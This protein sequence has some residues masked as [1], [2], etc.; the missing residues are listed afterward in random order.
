MR[1]Q[2]R[3]GGLL[4]AASL[5]LFGCGLLS[6]GPRSPGTFSY[7]GAMSGARENQ[8]ATLLHDGRVLVAG[9][10][11]AFSTAL[12]SAE[13]YDPKTGTFAKTASMSVAR[14]WDTATILPSGKV[15][16]AGGMDSSGDPLA[17]AELYDPKTAIFTPSGPMTTPRAG[18]T[19]TLL[20]DGRVLLVGG[21][22]DQSGTVVNSS[23]E[24]FDPKTN[25]F[26]ST[27]SMGGPRIYHTATLLHD[28]RVLVVGGGSDTAEIYDPATAAFAL[29]G[30]E[31]GDR[32]M[33]TAT[34]LSDGRV[35][36]VGGEPDTTASLVSAEIYDT[37]TGRFN[38]TG[39]MHDARKNHVAV[40]LADGNVLVAGGDDSTDSGER[41]LASAELYNPVSGT[42]SN[43]GTL[44]AARV[45][46]T[47]T[48]LGNGKVL[49]VGG[50]GSSS[51]ELYWP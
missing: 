10:V 29:T 37:A 2:F 30:T 49:I 36:L 41:D 18:H 8:T 45:D 34:L 5:S 51:A 32:S 3:I 28:G 14:F 4:V 7:T 1:R 35:L 26:G 38:S 27:G 48:V 46:A 44:Q 50:Y 33:H 40:L 19:A 16:I 24:L 21:V 43:T 15:L 9:G 47:A 11:N 6:G 25:A 17:S 20:A 13:L 31:A 23:A 39:S 12:A 22:A 42:F